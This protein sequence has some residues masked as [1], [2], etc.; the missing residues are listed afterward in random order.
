[1]RNALRFGKPPTAVKNLFFRLIKPDGGVPTGHDGQAIGNL[2]VAA[3][4][5]DD[6]RAIGA[7]YGGQAIERVSVI[8]IL[9]EVAVGVVHANGPEALDRYVA[10]FKPIHARAVIVRRRPTQICGVLG[11]IATP[12]RCRA[13]QVLDGV[14][15]VLGAECQVVVG[16]GRPKHQQGIA[17]LLLACLIPLWH[18]EFSSARL[19]YRNG[20]LKRVYLLDILRVGGVDQRAYRHEN[21]AR[22]DRFFA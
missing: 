5:L 18:D 15:F 14:N 2:A 13:D 19:A 12:A 11:R 22:A 4:V 3:A 17:Y 21:I 8:R 6:D 9:L 7:F 20:I 10:D 16:N 1:M